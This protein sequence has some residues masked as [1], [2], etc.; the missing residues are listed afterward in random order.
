[1]ELREE[2]L[3]ELCAALRRNRSLRLLGC[4]RAGIDAAGGVKLAAMLRSNTCLTS[5]DLSRN[6]LGG[7]SLEWARA[8]ADSLRDNGTLLTLALTL[9]LTRTLTRTRTLTLPLTLAAISARVILPALPAFFSLEPLGALLLL[10]STASCAPQERW[11]T[12]TPPQ[13]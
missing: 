12:A 1:M 13:G 6:R 9:A 11:L 7:G 3:R 10:S 5:L 4:A 2:T 8:L